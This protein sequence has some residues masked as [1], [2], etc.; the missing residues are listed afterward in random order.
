MPS[1]HAVP[2]TPSVFQ[3]LSQLPRCEQ[4][5]QS[6]FHC[7]YTLPSSVSCKSC[8]C[9]SYENTG[10]VGVFFPFWNSLVGCWGFDPG[11]ECLSKSS[12][13]CRQLSHCHSCFKSFRCNTYG[14][15]R[16]CWA[17]L[18][19]WAQFSLQGVDKKGLAV[20]SDGAG[21]TM[22]EVGLLPFARV[23][24]QVAT[25]VL[26][27]YR[28]RF[29]KH[30]FTQPQLLAVLCLMRY[31]DWTFREA[32]VRLREHQ[33]LRAALHLPAV[34]DYTTLYRFLRRLEDDTVDRGLQETVLRL[35]RRRSRPLSAA[36]DGTGLSDTSVSTFFHRR[37]EQHAHG[38]RS[39]RPW[40]K[41]LI[42]VDVRQQIL[43][44][45]R[46]RQGPGC[47]A[48]SL[49]GLLDVAAR[50]AP[51]GVVLADAE[52]DS[53][54][55][56]Q[57]IRQRL[58]AKSVIPARRRE[59]DHQERGTSLHICQEPP[60]RRSTCPDLVGRNLP[61]LHFP[62]RTP[63]RSEH[64]DRAISIFLTTLPP[65]LPA[66]LLLLSCATLLV[67]FWGE[68]DADTRGCLET[69]V[70]IHRF[71]ELAQTHA[72]GGGV[73]ARLRAESRRGRRNVGAGGAAARFRLRALAQSGALAGSGAS[74]G[75]RKDFAR[76]GLL[77]G[78]YPSNPLSRRLLQFSAPNSAGAHSLRLRRAGRLSDGLRVRAP[79]EEHP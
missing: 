53:E 5:E 77:R 36:I 4:N 42:V 17:L 33:E 14:S 49:P 35:R 40:L 68:P 9:H 11:K 3:H 39:R 41:W 20:F 19:S 65:Y 54:A 16:K 72:G 56:H 58:G 34:P 7:P 43:L 52:F 73:R 8:A 75:G 29:S 1:R 30:Q 48:R 15:P 2:L 45:Q 70:R 28:T 63:V 62:Q 31:E 69:V 78:S 74:F 60:S 46:A 66:S 18:T 13:D 76:A 27:P 64:R 57:H 55:N 47:D 50:G 79:V 12:T 71:G 23:A 6:N 61:P 26:P 44:A 37:L 59:S 10:G 38:P 22:A 25:Q 67:L 21:G 24:L 51:I 32:E